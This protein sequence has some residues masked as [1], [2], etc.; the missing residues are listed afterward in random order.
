M[1]GASLDSRVVSWHLAIL[2]A[3]SMESV[4]VVR[5]TTLTD[6]ALDAALDE[7]VQRQ[8]FDLGRLVDG[9]HLLA[10]R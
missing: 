10:S 8:P 9:A 5:Q 4:E 1:H 2:V 6:D 3:L 7:T